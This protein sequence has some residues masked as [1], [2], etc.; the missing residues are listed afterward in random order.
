MIDTV[1]Y[2]CETPPVIGKYHFILAYTSLESKP[3][4]GEQPFFS[5]AYNLELRQHQV[6]IDW[7]DGSR[8]WINTPISCLTF[9]REVIN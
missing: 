7:L 6:E 8:V 2:L 3:L 9:E 5:F 4:W 1:H